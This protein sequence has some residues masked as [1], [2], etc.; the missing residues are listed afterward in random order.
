MRCLGEH[1]RYRMLELVHVFGALLRR[2]LAADA[3]V[4]LEHAD[5]VEG[6]LARKRHPDDAA[7]LRHIL[8]F[9]I[10]ER[11]MPG[12]DRAVALPV[13]VAQVEGVHIP[14][15]ATDERK[16]IGF[17]FLPAVAGD[18]G[19]A[20]LAVLLPVAVGHQLE[21]RA[22]LASL[23]IGRNV[24]LRTGD[25]DASHCGAMYTETAPERDARARH[26]LNFLS[27]SVLQFQ[28]EELDRRADATQAVRAER[29]AFR[30]VLRHRPR[31][32]QRRTEH[33]AQRFDSRRLVGRGTDHRELNTR[34]RPDIPV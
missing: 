8:H 10:A 7:V 3:A 13:R 12:E 18:H 23:R 6:W 29:A 11:L 5:L 27:A 24:G 28:R 2:D 4:T 16:R 15:L 9:E 1:S 17:A 34:R 30:Y 32:Q 31:K 25:R 21:E 22:L 14:G 26:A 19:E 20:K 33:L